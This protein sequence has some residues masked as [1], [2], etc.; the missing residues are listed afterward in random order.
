MRRKA[1]EERRRKEDEQRRIEAERRRVEELQKAAGGLLDAAEAALGRGEPDAARLALTRWKDA[2]EL[3]E[4]LLRLRH[5]QH[6]VRLLTLR[7]QAEVDAIT[8]PYGIGSVGSLEVDGRGVSGRARTLILHG[9]NGL[10]RVQTELSIRRLFKMLPSG[11]LMASGARLR[12]S[13]AIKKEAE[14]TL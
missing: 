12:A 4:A 8:A 7:T 10:A 9:S 14:G 13:A 2:P 1:E 6:D 11:M 3:S 5:L